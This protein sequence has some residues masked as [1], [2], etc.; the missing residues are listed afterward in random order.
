MLV[1]KQKVVPPTDSNCGSAKKREPGTNEQRIFSF[2]APQAKDFIK[3]LL[4]RQGSIADPSKT[5][6]EKEMQTN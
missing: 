6:E 5:K 3:P 1:D 2:W 4:S